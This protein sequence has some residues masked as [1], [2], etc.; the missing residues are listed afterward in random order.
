MPSDEEE[1]QSQLKSFISLK[2]SS[3]KSQIG[4]GSAQIVANRSQ[5][6]P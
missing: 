4:E 5:P 1:S 3:D 2:C 6:Q